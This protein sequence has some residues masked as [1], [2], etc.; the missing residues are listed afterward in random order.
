MK[1][2][3]KTEIDKKFH[4]LIEVMKATDLKA[5][6]LAK[7][8]GVSPSTLTRFLKDPENSRMPMDRTLDAIAIKLGLPTYTGIALNDQAETMPGFQEDGA[9]ELTPTDLEE[10]EIAQNF[11]YL[12]NRRNHLKFWAMKGRALENHGILDGDIL[13]VDYNAEPKTGDVC[14][15]SLRDEERITAKSVFR[16]LMTF[17]PAPICITSTNDQSIDIEEK[18]ILVDGIKAR[19][20]GVVSMSFR[21]YGQ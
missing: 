21:K 17:K 20:Y 18:M 2:D 4:W 6:P 8:G 7:A 1:R 19:I 5:T 16:I 11:S 9:T 10:Q 13:V 3:K 14:L 15:I 12:A